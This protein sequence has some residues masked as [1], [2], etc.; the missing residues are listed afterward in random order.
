MKYDVK[1]NKKNN[2]LTNKEGEIWDEFKQSWKEA[3]MLS[4][5]DS[6]IDSLLTMKERDQ[7]LN[8]YPKLIASV[9]EP[10]G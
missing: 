6:G 4:K 3:M 10:L 1:K 8:L 9:Q 5:L 2:T 7:A